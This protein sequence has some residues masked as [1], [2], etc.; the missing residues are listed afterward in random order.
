MKPC[1]IPCEASW[2]WMAALGGALVM[3][4]VVGILRE[5]ERRRGSQD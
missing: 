2:L 1:T 4:A 5:V 3:L